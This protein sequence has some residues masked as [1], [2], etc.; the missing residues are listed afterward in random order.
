M[1]PGSVGRWIL[2][3]T[4]GRW[5]APLKGWWK[6]TQQ[7]G[8]E[9]QTR[10]SWC[11]AIEVRNLCLQFMFSH[12]RC[13]RTLRRAPRLRGSSMQNTPSKS[14]CSSFPGESPCHRVALELSNMALV[15]QYIGKAEQSAEAPEW[16]QISPVILR[17]HTPHADPHSH[18]FSRKRTRPHTCPY[19]RPHRL[20]SSTPHTKHN[21]LFPLELP[22]V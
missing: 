1:S 12:C 21:I 17:I 22:P 5:W 18:A 15:N 9:T 6:H 19:T 7:L 13:N 14:A 10:C 16:A 20:R 11:I 8:N 2:V 3:S 4:T